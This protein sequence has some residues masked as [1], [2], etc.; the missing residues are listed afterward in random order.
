MSLALDA[1]LEADGGLERRRGGLTK[2]PERDRHVWRRHPD[3]SAPG[4]KGDPSCLED[5]VQLRLW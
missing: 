2:L 5:Q 4:I 1:E 3:V